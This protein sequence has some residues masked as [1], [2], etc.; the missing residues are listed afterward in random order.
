[1]DMIAQ[2]ERYPSLQECFAYCLRGCTHWKSKPAIDDVKRN[3]P[4]NAIG[5]AEG[6]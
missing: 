5:P 1:M 6:S 4:V 3:G 2:I